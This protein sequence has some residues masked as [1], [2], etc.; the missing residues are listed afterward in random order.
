[1]TPLQLTRS[2]RSLNRLQQ[3]ARV[4]TQQG[5]GHFVDRLNLRRYVSIPGVLPRRRRDEVTG[6]GASAIGR[7]LARVCDELGPTFVKLGQTLTTRPDVIPEEVIRELRSLQDH[8]CPFD[9]SSARTIIEEELGTPIDQCFGHLAD[10]PFASGSIGQVY[11]ATTHD[12]MEVVVKVKRPDIDN[13]VRLDMHILSWFADA[14]ERLVPELRGYRP[15]QLVHE[16]AETL[17]REMDFVSEASAT[18]RIG[19]ALTDHEHVRVPQV[20]WDLCGSRVLTLEALKGR[21]LDTVLEA[22]EPNIDRKAL[23]S[24]LLDAYLAQFF[25]VGVF[26]AD[27]HPGNILVSPPARIGLIDFGQVGVLSDEQ[28]ALFLILIVAAVNRDPDLIVEVLDDLDAL[29]PKTGRERLSR[30]LRLLLDKYYGLPLK[31]L[32]LSVVFVEATEIIRA[33][34]VTVPSNVMVLVKALTTVSGVAMRLDP[35]LDLVALLKPRMKRM[36]ADRLSPARMAKAAGLAAWQTWGILRSAPSTIKAVLRQLSRGDWEV[37]VRHENLERLT[38]ELDRSSNR[39]AISV[40]I[41]AVIVGSSMLVGTAGEL[42]F[43]IPLRMLGIIGYL[44]AGVL[45]LGLVWAIFR[46]GRLY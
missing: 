36:V 3:I 43:G 17:R 35:E 19:D 37:K 22:D 8:V 20:R 39:L 29:G 25:E 18:A 11:R 45:G 5:F 28:S 1:M 31:R 46:S 4:L 32:D 12:G 41:A 9:T 38:S 42:P 34:D 33:N 2:V 21:N 15:A 30:S 23:A 26:H 27:P 40:V 13:I 24:R 6:S 7:R 16:L 44:I 14:A 10:A